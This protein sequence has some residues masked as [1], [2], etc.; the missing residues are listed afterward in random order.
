MHSRVYQLISKDY[1][2]DNFIPGWWENEHCDYYGEMDGKD[3]AEAIELLG[4]REKV[5]GESVT[6]GK[7]YLN[8]AWE[9]FRS[10]LDKV[11]AITKDQFLGEPANPYSISVDVHELNMSFSDDFGCWFLLGSDMYTWAELERY[12][13]GETFRVGKVWDYHN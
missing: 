2:T 10:A 1:K 4:W 8:L 9:R 6:I 13:A 3:R 7:G 5:D 11:S 12:Q